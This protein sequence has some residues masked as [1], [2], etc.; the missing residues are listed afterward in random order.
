MYIRTS[1]EP[2]LFH[3]LITRNLREGCDIRTSFFRKCIFLAYMLENFRFT[4]DESMNPILS[5]RK[6]PRVDSFSQPEGLP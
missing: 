1:V 4:L 6:Y 2:L 5:P 3:R